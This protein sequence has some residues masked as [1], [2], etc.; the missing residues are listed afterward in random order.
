MTSQIAAG[1]R[2]SHPEHHHTALDMVIDLGAEVNEMADMAAHC[3]E[4][5]KKSAKIYSG[6]KAFREFHWLT[7]TIK[8]N[9]NGK[10]RGI[11]LNRP[12]R[13]VF[14]LS[15]DVEQKLEKF[16]KYIALAGWVTEVIKRRHEFVEI[17]NSSDDGVVKTLETAGSL[18]TATNRALSGIAPFGVHLV[19]AALVKGIHDLHGPRRWATSV[20]KFDT[21]VTTLYDKWTDDKNIAKWFNDTNFGKS[22][23]NWQVSV[24][25][26]DRKMFRSII[27]YVGTHLTPPHK[28]IGIISPHR[29]APAKK[30]F[31]PLI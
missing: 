7:S 10:L 26:F 28:H 21:R 4:Y 1:P 15:V 12:L 2:G 9:K 24:E 16:D 30:V 22:Y 20:K 14:D 27:H 17:W 5:L 31:M 3:A 18:G 23:G 8:L 11:L 6:E 19:D 29:K 25:K 13:A